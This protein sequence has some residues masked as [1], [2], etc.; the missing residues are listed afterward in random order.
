LAPNLPPDEVQT[1]LWLDLLEQQVDRILDLVEG[2]C[3][4]FAQQRLQLRERLFDR[5]QI[6]TVGRQIEQ[7]PMAQIASRTVLFL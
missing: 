5:I 3:V 7:A 2:A 4:G 1:F 6:R